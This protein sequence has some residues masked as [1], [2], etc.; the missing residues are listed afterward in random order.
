MGAA[1]SVQ[2][3]YKDA[4]KWLKIYIDKKTYLADFEALD[5][6]HNG[7]LSFVEFHKWVSDNG[8]LTGLQ[9][10]LSYMLESFT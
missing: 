6:D 9:T 1:A 2:S 10:Y 3:V 8:R 5:A 4:L 7:G